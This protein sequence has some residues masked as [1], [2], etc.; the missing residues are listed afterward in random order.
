MMP[1]G[2]PLFL[3]VVINIVFR[4]SCFDSSVMGRVNILCV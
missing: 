1:I 3:A 4:S 2:Y